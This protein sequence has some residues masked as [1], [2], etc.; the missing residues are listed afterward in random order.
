ATFTSIQKCLNLTSG[1]LSSHIKKL[2]NRGLIDVKKMFIDLKP[3]TEVYISSKGKDSII[4]YAKSLS[5]VFQRM[6][7]K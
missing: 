6:L 2:Q 5:N 4:D 3:T 7:K 1:N